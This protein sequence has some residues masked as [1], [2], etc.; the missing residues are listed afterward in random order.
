M[1]ASEQRREQDGGI[2]ELLEGFKG[3]DGG[4]DDFLAKLLQGLNEDQ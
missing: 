2:M 4:S 3:M 1:E